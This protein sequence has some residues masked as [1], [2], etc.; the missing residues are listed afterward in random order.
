MKA[1]TK[2]TK[3]S[4]KMSV[5]VTCYKCKNTVDSRNT[6]LYSPQEATKFNIKHLKGT[7]PYYFA[8]MQLQSASISGTNAIKST[9]D[10]KKRYHTLL[11][12]HNRWKS[13]FSGTKSKSH[14]FLTKSCT[15]TLLVFY[16]NKNY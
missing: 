8:K 11:L 9:F 10:S 1:Q 5:Y 16:Q 6:I 12:P 7:V 13:V 2:S 14:L 15:K 4:R 3:S